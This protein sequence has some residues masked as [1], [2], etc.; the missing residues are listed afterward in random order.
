LTASRERLDRLV[1]ALLR[2]ETI[3]ADTLQEILG[4]RPSAD[5]VV[6]GADGA[7]EIPATDQIR[8]G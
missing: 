8:K 7:A 4:P 2:E 3:G 5:G 1:A 6:P